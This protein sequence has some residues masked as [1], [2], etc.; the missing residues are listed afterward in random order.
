M[1]EN[2]NQI[3]DR[4]KAILA[5]LIQMAGADE[6]LHDNE[7]Q[8][9]GD[10]AAQIDIF[11][12]ELEEIYS[13]SGSYILIPPRSEEDRMT[14]LYYLLFTMRADGQIQRK[15]EELCFKAGLRLGFNHQ[16]VS[17]LIAVMKAYLK[18]DIPPNAL[19]DKVKK[20][21]N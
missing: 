2:Y 9:I 18:K 19:I 13:D 5:M 21:L 6:K 1:L 8:F 14:I 11:P 4:K 17:D 3:R 20:Y 16:L 12:G 15:E 7:K 10:V